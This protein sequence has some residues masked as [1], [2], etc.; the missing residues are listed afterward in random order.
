MG[1]A[2]VWRQRVEARAAGSTEE[3]ETE[4]TRKSAVEELQEASEHNFAEALTVA[5]RHAER[6][7]KA[8]AD[9]SRYL[10]AFRHTF[11]AHSGDRPHYE[12]C[13]KCGLNIREP[14]H[15]AEA[16][17]GGAVGRVMQEKL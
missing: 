8:E 11:V 10:R 1:N 7:D 16:G 3:R 2:D 6:L 17:C 14:V 12:T 9:V 4:M 13:L 5:T 15:Y